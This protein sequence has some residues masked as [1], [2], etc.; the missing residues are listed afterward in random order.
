[1]SKYTLCSLALLAAL[2]PLVASG[3]G[4]VSLLPAHA[5]DLV[6]VG[7]TPASH[8]ATGT[9]KASLE[10]AP[11]SFAWALDEHAVLQRPTP[12]ISE[13]R[14]FWRRIKA[15]ELVEGTVIHTTAPGAVLRL[16]PMAGSGKTTVTTRQL[17]LQ[18]DGVTYSGDDA[19]D[20]L[21]DTTQLKAAGL[22]LPERS[23][24]MRLRRDLGA[25]E[26]RLKLAGAGSDMLLHVFEPESTEVFSLGSA[27][28]SVLDGGWLH[29]SAR[30]ASAQG[31]QLREVAGTIAA[32]NGRLFDLDF[33]ARGANEWVARTRVDAMAGIGDGLWEVHAK[34]VSDD[35][36]V[37]RDARTAFN[38]AHAGARLVGA[39]DVSLAK[40]GALQVSLP[41]EVASASRYNLAAVLYGS[42]AKGAMHPFAIAH[43]ALWA[44]PGI[45]KVSLQ[46]DPALLGKRSL[47][48][49]FEL[50]DVRLT[51]QATLG[52]IERR[53]RALRFEP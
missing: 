35:G 18:H 2:L 25:G 21:A 29:V 41:I 47:G 10:R 32:P 28:D 52:L 48:A 14:E 4:Q 8:P 22:D 46:F 11:V 24:A 12:H 27:S 30:F 39:A 9:T 51:D 1:M 23:I 20:Q 15:D 5:G 49:P 36:A 34:G 45:A 53:E 40:G 37:Q 17:V 7:L 13:S 31:K 50:R 33:V 3:A 26:F 44:E 38:A 6:P 43:S 16:S 42:D 19:F